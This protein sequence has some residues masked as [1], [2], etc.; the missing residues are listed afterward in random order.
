MIH[1]T[2]KNGGSETHQKK[3]V[4]GLPGII[5][6][7][8]QTPLG[9]DVFGGPPKNPKPK[10]PNLSRYDWK[11]GRNVKS[12]TAAWYTKQPFFN[13]L[14]WNHPIETTIKN[15]LFGVPA[16]SLRTLSF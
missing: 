3:M 10:R 5:S 9:L 16:V 8:F 2:T 15:W 13:V 4:V 7:G 6:L 11:T 14:I 1:L 12:L